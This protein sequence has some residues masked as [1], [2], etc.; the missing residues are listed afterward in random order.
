MSRKLLQGLLNFQPCSTHIAGYVVVTFIVAL[1]YSLAVHF[2]SKGS[3]CRD[4]SFRKGDCSIIE[5]DG[6]ALSRVDTL[7]S[8]KLREL[9]INYLIVILQL[10]LS[11]D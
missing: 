7:T 4:D 10:I 8:V 11:V 2:R 9:L 6:F 1:F 3:K 5:L